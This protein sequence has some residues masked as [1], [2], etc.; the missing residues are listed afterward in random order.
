MSIRVMNLVWKLNLPTHLR[1]VLL[2]LA[3]FSDD[4]G[5]SV[6]PSHQTIANLTGLSKRT[7]QRLIKRLI[8]SGLLIIV[9]NVRG[10]HRP[11]VYQIDLTQVRSLIAEAEHDGHPNDRCDAQSA[12]GTENRG[13]SD[14]KE[15]C[16]SLSPPRQ[17][18]GDVVSLRREIRG[19]IRGSRGDIEDSQGRQSLAPE[20]SRPVREK[21]DDTRTTQSAQTGDRGRTFDECRAELVAQIGEAQYKTWFEPLHWERYDGDVLIV[22]AP[23]R[24]IRDHVDKTFNE[25]L[26]LVFGCDVQVVMH[27]HRL[28]S[29]DN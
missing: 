7:V 12:S 28:T 26:Q 23:T 9:R 8:A 24:F 20:S 13:D 5:G 15:R 1:F 29:P 17:S 11:R 21:E 27:T 25:V 18:G 22:G 14:N 19:D 2:S 16:Q 3:K 10:G 4:D 6:F